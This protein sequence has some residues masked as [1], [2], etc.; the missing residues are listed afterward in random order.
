VIPA[1]AE[2]TPEV[3]ALWNPFLSSARPL[4]IAFIN[5]LF[6][7][8]QRKDLPDIVYR[9]SRN[10]TWND[11]ITSPEFSVL[12]RSLANP[13]ATPTFNLVERSN[14]VSTFVL[15]QFLTRRRGNI[16]LAR[17]DELSWRQF[18]DNDVILFGPFAIDGGQS[19]LPVRTAFVVDRAGVRN[20]Q[21]LAGEPPI[22]EDPPDHH[23]SDGEGLE[24]VSVLPGPLGRTTVM[25]FS[26]KH[27]WGVTGGVQALVDPVFT[28]QVVEKLRGASGEIPRYYQ[29]VFKIVYRDGTLT[30]AS[31]VTH[32]ALTLTQNS[33]EARTTKR[34][35]P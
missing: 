33:V 28:R 25:T 7:R 19:A 10:N 24:L 22:Y 16:S 14:L 23:P 2:S 31:Y 34:T 8:L 27:K 21:P 35:E 29:I 11:A 6:V 3:D 15:S 5:P 12:N 32:R 20:L 18:A 17:A 30:K 9:T 1:S 4:L 13:L 26:S